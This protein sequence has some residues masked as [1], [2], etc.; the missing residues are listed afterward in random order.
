MGPRRLIPERVNQH[1]MTICACQ[2]KVNPYDLLSANGADERK[3]QHLSIAQTGL[4]REA[5]TKER[6]SNFEAI[7]P[8]ELNTRASAEFADNFLQQREVLREQNV[9]PRV[10][11]DR[12]LPHL[13]SGSLAV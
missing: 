11:R 9:R 12:L 5:P 13:L 4:T 10:A 3:R 1:L 6:A 2:R 8:D 7:V